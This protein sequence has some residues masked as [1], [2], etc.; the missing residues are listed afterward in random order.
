MKN[1]ILIFLIGF[2]ALL[3]IVGKAQVAIKVMQYNLQGNVNQ[4]PDK[5]TKMANQILR[6]A[7]DF[8]TTQETTLGG[9]NFLQ[10]KFDEL[11]TKIYKIAT[12]PT[13]DL[14]IFY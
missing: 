11:P 5:A 13:N 9:S 10:Q 1:F 14:A 4:I 12:G 8:L 6:Q 7:P 2:I 3:P